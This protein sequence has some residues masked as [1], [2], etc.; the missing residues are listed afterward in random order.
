MIYATVTNC[1]GIESVTYHQGYDQPTATLQVVCTGHALGLNDLI[2]ADIGYT[3]SHGA[4]F[5]GR[6]KE[7]RTF[8]SADG[9]KYT[10]SCFDIL[11]QASD[12]FIVADDPDNPYEA[13]NVAAED[14][15]E[16]LLNMA[17]IVDYSST[18]PGLTLAVTTPQQIDR[19]FVWN[20]IKQI[21]D[22]AAYHIWCN[23]S[24]QVQF[25]DL[26]PYPV[27]GASHSFTTG[28]AGELLE[29]SRA[30]SEENLR[31]KVVVYGTAG[32]VAI[33]SAVSPHLPDGFYKT[34][35]FGHPLIDSQQ[36][37][38][39][40]AA[41]NLTKWNRATERVEC[42]ILGDHSVQFGQTVEVVEAETATSG[43]WFVHD[44]VHSINKSGFVTQFALTK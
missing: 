33:A 15:V 6:V 2:T 19:M 4:V 7:I 8:R 13:D 5:Y 10:I 42:Q 39:D 30:F 37:A 22:W 29:L 23:V 16:A 11:I 14:L 20:M 26:K 28:D 17:Q 21:A 1:T 31:N 27:G 9:F 25:K 36:A 35:A 34:A 18:S 12:Y 43:N 44:I 41:W 3:G 38:E 24:G 40:A 32:I